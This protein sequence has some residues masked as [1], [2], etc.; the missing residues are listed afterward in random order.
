MAPFPHHYT[1]TAKAAAASDSV[2]AGSPGVADSATDAPTEFGGRVTGG[3]P[4]LC[5]WLQLPTALS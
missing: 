4:N 5:S 2:A 3:V 1:V